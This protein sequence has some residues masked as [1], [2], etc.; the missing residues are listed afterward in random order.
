MTKESV[1]QAL[2]LVV[3]TSFSITAGPP[4]PPSSLSRKLV[5]MAGEKTRIVI[6]LDVDVSTNGPPRPVMVVPK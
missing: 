4:V 6:V 2:A 1:S 3:T 5:P